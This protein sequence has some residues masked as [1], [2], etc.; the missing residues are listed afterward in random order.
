VRAAFPERVRG[1]LR[2]VRDI[3][4]DAAL[5]DVYRRH[6]IYVV[7]SFFEGQPLTMLEAAAAGLAVV[8]TGI[9]GMKDFV[10]RDVNGLLVEPGDPE[11]LERAIGA[12]A[13]DSER[14]ARLGAKARE[15]ARAFTWRSTAEKFV[16]AAERAA[17]RGLT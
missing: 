16:E 17:A 14:A 12:L 7:P 15:R 3:R 2:L 5:L 4:G 9:C 10:E 1:R 8:T 6:A 13:D 11:G